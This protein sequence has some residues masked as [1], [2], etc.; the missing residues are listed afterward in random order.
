MKRHSTYTFFFYRSI[1]PDINITTYNPYRLKSH[2]IHIGIKS[3]W[4][5]E[6]LRDRSIF[7]KATAVKNSCL[8]YH[9]YFICRIFTQQRKFF[10][11]APFIL[12]VGSVS[13]NSYFVEWSSQPRISDEIFSVPEVICSQVSGSHC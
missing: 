5:A 7:P 12:M 2:Q 10:H 3:Y 11:S 13:L 4:V 6:T 8:L 9:V 1:S